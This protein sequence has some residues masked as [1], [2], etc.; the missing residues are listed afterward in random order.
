MSHCLQPGDRAGS[1]G[2]RQSC[3]LQE[4]GSR[5]STETTRCLLEWARA[6]LESSQYKKMALWGRVS[7]SCLT[8]VGWVGK[9]PLLFS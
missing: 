5:L 7:V 3:D 4:L 6:E 8:N 2:G 9:D 1:Y